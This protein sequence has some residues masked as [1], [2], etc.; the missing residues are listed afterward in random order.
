MCACDIVIQWINCFFI[1]LYFQF[2]CPWKI[3]V[4]SETASFLNSSL[5]LLK[6]EFIT[7][8]NLLQQ[9]LNLLIISTVNCGIV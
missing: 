2:V 8:F 4:N 9:I 5:Y 1:L 6:H 3:V 7:L